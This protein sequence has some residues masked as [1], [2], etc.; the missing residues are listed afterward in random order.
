MYSTKIAV[1]RAKILLLVLAGLGFGVVLVLGLS[2]VAT[3]KATAA[4]PT[5]QPP[6][7]TGNVDNSAL[8]EVSGMAASRRQPGV[9]YVHNDGSKA[10]SVVYAINEQGAS[11]ATYRLDDVE[12][13]DM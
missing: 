13:E 2:A 8:K 3:P 10:G 1:S 9:F 5:F 4:C 7:Q 11:L 12:P 6:Q